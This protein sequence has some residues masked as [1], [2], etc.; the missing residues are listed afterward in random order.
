[1]KKYIEMTDMALQ[2]YLKIQDNPQ[3]KIYEAMAY[4]LFAGGKRLRPVIMLMTAKMC[5]KNPEICL[6]FSQRR[7]DLALRRQAVGGLR[8]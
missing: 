2:E 5:G 1:M 3:K 6:P 8:N 4:S 7:C